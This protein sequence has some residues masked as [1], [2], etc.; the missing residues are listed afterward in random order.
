V[1]AAAGRAELRI[2]E[3]AERV[4][5]TPRTIRYY[6][7]IG[8]LPAG[9]GRAAGS[10]RTYAEA[11]VER[12]RHVLRLKDLLGVSLE[13]LKLL[14][15]AEDAR[16]ALRAE[17]HSSDDAARRREILREA[18]AHVDRQL[19][20]VRARRAEIERLE[21]DLADRRGRILARLGE[22][23]GTAATRS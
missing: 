10:H 21:H 6:E 8:L 13:D 18:R 1:T 20:L 9:V 5:T 16:A 12:L 19:A 17:F 7:E 15:D 23:E 2:G 14:V 3:V 4:G 22:L 11:D